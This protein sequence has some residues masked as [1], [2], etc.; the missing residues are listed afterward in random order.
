MLPSTGAGADVD[1]DVDVD[2]A[3]TSNSRHLVH[4][5][6]TFLPHHLYSTTLFKTSEELL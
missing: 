4:P 2:D 3:Q 6:V 5:R 1:V